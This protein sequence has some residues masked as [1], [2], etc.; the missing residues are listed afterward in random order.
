[1]ARSKKF[2][3]GTINNM[4]ILTIDKQYQDGSI[5]TEAQLDAAFASIQTLLNTTGLGADN[6][7]GQLN[8][9]ERAS[10]FGRKQHKACNKRCKHGEDTGQRRY[11]G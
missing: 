10:N 8:R 7:S 5:L 4:P 1:V 9:T 3:W 6:I 2:D 11:T